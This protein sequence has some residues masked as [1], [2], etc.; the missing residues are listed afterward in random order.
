MWKQTWLP[1]EKVH[2]W[3]IFHIYVSLLKGHPLVVKRSLLDNPSFSSMTFLSYTIPFSSGYS[4]H[5]RLM[6]PEGV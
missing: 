6:T 4:S 1:K 5:P 2:K 3:L